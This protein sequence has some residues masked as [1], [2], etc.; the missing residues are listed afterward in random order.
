[1][2]FIQKNKKMKIA[3]YVFAQLD[4]Y[5]TMNMIS[6]RQLL[7]NKFH[8][9]RTESMASWVTSRI[10]YYLPGVKVLYPNMTNIRIHL[11]GYQE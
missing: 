1:M 7:V 8:I 5:S 9:H 4:L 11:R 10:F 6:C 3:T 2:K